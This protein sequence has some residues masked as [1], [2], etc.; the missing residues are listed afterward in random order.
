MH[1]SQLVFETAS[2]MPP[3]KKFALV[4]ETPLPDG[5]SM[6]LT[7]GG[8]R[9]FLAIYEGTTRVANAAVLATASCATLMDQFNIPR[10]SVNYSV[11]PVPPGGSVGV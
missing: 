9:F 6:R 8:S 7:S 1:V 10:V 4:L 5:K 2:F 3:Q 11:A